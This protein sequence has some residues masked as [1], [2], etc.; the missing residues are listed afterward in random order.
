MTPPR[1][2]LVITTFYP[3]VGGGETHALLIATRLRSLGSE[4]E[5]LTRRTARDLPP[6]DIINGIRVFRVGPIR[7]P[8]WGK[9]LMLVPVLWKLFRRRQHGDLIFV[10]GLRI[11]GI[12]GVLA[13]RLL[14]KP[15]VLRAA[16]CG[17]LSGAYIWNSPHGE[18][19]ERSPA[20]LIASRLINVRNRL[21]LKADAF[22]AISTA[23]AEECAAA[24]VPGHKIALINNG[25]DTSLFSPLSP[26]EKKEMREKLGLP[27]GFAF[28][29]SGK[30]NKGKGLPM[31]L[32]A[33]HQ[34]LA[35]HP[36]TLLVLIGSGD[37][38]FLSCEEELRHYVNQNGLSN[39][40]VFTGY[41]RK[42][43]VYLAACDAFV[44]PSENESL[45]NAVIEACACGLP[46]LASR[47]GGIPDTVEDGFNGRLL[48]PGDENAWAAAM[49]DLIDKPE[50]AAIWGAQA[51]QRAE[52]RNSIGAV[53]RRH[54]EL[55]QNI[56]AVQDAPV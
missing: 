44:F 29:Y 22:L 35:T 40:V 7:F 24:G 33:M 30:L 45:S 4:V 20:R 54:L 18:I 32:K 55:F 13:G 15:V 14:D 10:S 12:A 37:Q 31:L 26:P 47:I 28:C 17:E 56:T 25:T 11:L 5:V 2:Q 21:L 19:S 34:L 27:E 39:R 50:K 41:V 8:R 6:T 9:Y 16:S 49:A 53:A 52:D 38:Q 46:C 43:E 1:I 36:K 51:R 48:P 23:I 3:F 42:V